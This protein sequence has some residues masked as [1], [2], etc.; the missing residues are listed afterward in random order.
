MKAVELRRQHHIGDNDAEQSA[1]KRLAKVSR[2]VCAPPRENTVA[3][4][5]D[6]SRDGLGAVERVRLRFAWRDVGVD[7]DGRLAQ[8]PRDGLVGG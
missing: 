5:H 3:R 8:P 7:G 2:K 6:F 4:G 1:K